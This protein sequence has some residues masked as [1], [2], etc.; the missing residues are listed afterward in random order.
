MWII[1]LHLCTRCEWINSI[2]HDA[3]R[4]KNYPSS[5]GDSLLCLCIITAPC[6]LLIERHAQ[7]NDSCRNDGGGSQCPWV[8][9]KFHSYPRFSIWKWTAP[10]VPTE[11]KRQCASAI[12]YLLNT[13]LLWPTASSWYYTGRNLSQLW[14]YQN[15][16]TESSIFNEHLLLFCTSPFPQDGG[17]PPPPNKEIRTLILAMEFQ[18]K[19]IPSIN[20]RVSLKG[21]S[22]PLS[23]FST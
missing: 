6:F 7:Q 22:V 14:D 15:A 1:R 17:K 21:R 16:E 19:C 2:T 10:L 3:E 23:S 13:S 20:L 9:G 11:K 5:E 8:R 4:Q 18:A 12:R